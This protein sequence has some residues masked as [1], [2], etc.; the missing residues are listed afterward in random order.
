MDN[1]KNYVIICNK[2]DSLLFKEMKQMEVTNMSC[3]VDE[4]AIQIAELWNLEK[5]TFDVVCFG[6]LLDSS[7]TLDFY[8]IENGTML[9]LLKK[10]TTALNH[11]VDSKDSQKSNIVETNNISSAHSSFAFTTEQQGQCI[12]LKSALLNSA[13]RQVIENLSDFDNR[14]NLMTVNHELRNDPSLFGVL[15]DSELLHAYINKNNVKNV[16]KRYPY[17]LEVATHVSATFHEE[18]NSSAMHQSLGYRGSLLN[19]SIDAISEDEEMDESETSS[20]SST[21]TN[22][23]MRRLSDPSSS[24]FASMLMQ[25][26]NHHN[27]N[28]QLLQQQHSS[29]GGGNN[30]TIITQDMLRQ[31]LQ[32]TSSSSNIPNM[33]GE[34]SSSSSSSSHHQ[35]HHHHQDHHHHQQSQCDTFPNIATNQ[36]RSNNELSEMMI[37]SRDSTRCNTPQPMPVPAAAAVNP[38]NDNRTPAQILIGWAPQL[39][40]MR[41]LGI[42][43]DIVAIQALEATNG[44]VQAAINII[45]SDMS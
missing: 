42:T 25:A 34:M 8:G 41:E 17:F 5:Q 22:G 31:A 26:Y 11:L 45:F 23:S 35:H 18:I 43:D 6:K 33:I 44:D 29:S 20:I 40:Q 15:S 4:L 3:T 2:I 24:S 14:E 13:F 10:K 12:A 36:D 28:R 32:S 37:T 7:K 16:L 21:N 1:N 30:S 38:N 9:Y 27:Q 19:Y 39:R